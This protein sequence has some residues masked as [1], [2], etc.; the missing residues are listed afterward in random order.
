[1]LN[2]GGATYHPKV[3]LGRCG[4]QVHAVVGS[5]NLTSGLVANVEAAIAMRG[6]L[7]DLAHVALWSW[8]EGVWSDPRAAAW[9]PKPDD[10][11]EEAIEPELLEQ[12]TIAIGAMPIVYTLGPSPKPNYISQITP[13]GIWVET[14]RSRTRHEGPQLVPPRMLN[15]AWDALRANGRLS[16]RELL[17]EMRIHRS[18]FVCTLLA[19]LPG[20]T[21]ESTSPIVLRYSPT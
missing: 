8:A 13:S 16:N 19:R 9:I 15:L 14:D 11:A 21:V 20:V 17:H 7:D 3:F 10:S 12:I 2:P 1:V 4:R 5:A 6:T 18:S